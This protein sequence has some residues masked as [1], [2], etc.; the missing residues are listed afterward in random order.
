[1]RIDIYLGLLFEYKTQVCM[2]IQYYILL[3]SKVHSEQLGFAPRGSKARLKVSSQF[4]VN[5]RL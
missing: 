3:I 5:A 2:S 1:M 4:S